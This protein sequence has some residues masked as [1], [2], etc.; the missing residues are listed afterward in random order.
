MRH[1]R[2]LDKSKTI[3]EG[4]LSNSALPIWKKPKENDDKAIRK[5]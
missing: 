2:D 5:K 4:V 1:V 3:D